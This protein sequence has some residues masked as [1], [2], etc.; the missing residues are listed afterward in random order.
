MITI[1]IKALPQGEQ[2][3]A[4]T[5][6]INQ[7]EVT[8]IFAS[9]LTRLISVAEEM[10][11]HTPAALTL[12]VSWLDADNPSDRTLDLHA[13]IEGHDDLPQ[14]GSPAVPRDKNSPHIH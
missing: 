10:T 11:G 7:A 14:G 4:H 6:C 12:T 9:L 13:V 1:A 3:F 5:E 8:E 2:D